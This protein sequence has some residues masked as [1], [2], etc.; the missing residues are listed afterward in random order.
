MPRWNPIVT[1]SGSALGAAHARLLRLDRHGDDQHLFSTR[2]YWS[3]AGCHSGPQSKKQRWPKYFDRGAGKWHAMASPAI[4]EQNAVPAGAPRAGQATTQNKSPAPANNDTVPH[5]QGPTAQ[6][7]WSEPDSR[8]VRP[9]TELGGAGW[10]G[11]IEHERPPLEWSSRGTARTA[12]GVQRRRALPAGTLAHLSC[13]HT[14][15][16]LRWPQEHRK[17]RGDPPPTPGHWRVPTA[18][19]EQQTPTEQRSAHSGPAGKGN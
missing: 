2:C 10:V 1:M 11:R 17:S 3:L 8:S 12:R 6:K 15:R 19:I 4:C 5:R 9:L 13:C 16:K 7:L 18:P 14:V